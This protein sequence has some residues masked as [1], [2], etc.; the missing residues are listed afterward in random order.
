MHRTISLAFAILI[1]ATTLA[2][3]TGVPGPEETE[4]FDRTVAGEPESSVVVVNRN[5]GVNVSA[6]D[7]D[8]VAIT[9]VKRTVYGRGE[10]AKVSIDVTEGDPLRIES[11]YTGINVRAGVD[12]TIR[13]PPDVVLQRV[14]SSNGGIELTGVRVAG[15]EL[16]T[17]NGPV[18]V[19]GARG[20]TLIPH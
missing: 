14:E 1:A 18:H 13:L 12:Y 4:V 17:S 6:W 8:Y 11:V 15:T 7:E 20:T 10:L 3:C 5:G 16:A 19:D 9:A 2:G